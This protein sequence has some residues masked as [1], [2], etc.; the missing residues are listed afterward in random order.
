MGITTG[1]DCVTVGLQQRPCFLQLRRLMGITTGHDCVT[2]GLQQR[3]CFLQLRRLMSV[4]TGNGRVFDIFH[5]KTY[6]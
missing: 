6:S 4:T 3:L 2:V 1:H 5:A